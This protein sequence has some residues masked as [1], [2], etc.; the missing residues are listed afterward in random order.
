[1][2]QSNYQMGPEGGDPGGILFHRSAGDFDPSNWRARLNAGAKRGMTATTMG[3]R[4]GTAAAGGTASAGDFNFGGG[5]ASQDPVF[6]DIGGGGGGGMVYNPR[7]NDGTPAGRDMYIPAGG[8][9]G[10]AGGGFENTAENDPDMDYTLA[11]LRKRYE[12]DGGAGRAIDLAG[13]KIREAALGEGKALAAGQSARGASG[14]GAGEI[15]FGNL[16]GRTLHRIAGAGADIAVQRERDKD[17]L[18]GSIASAAATRS[19]TNL[20]NRQMALQQ[21]ESLQADRRAEEAAKMAR[22][23]AALE[24]L[25]DRVAGPIMPAPPTRQRPG[26]R[27]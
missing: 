8:G 15:Q 21:W 13:G 10:G 19:G 22:Q 27:R 26:L 5:G 11:E 25:K 17:A 24:L 2:A 23:M 18:L 20:A 16:A 7:Y 9:A 14:T 3:R 12:G 1:M 6:T 4:P